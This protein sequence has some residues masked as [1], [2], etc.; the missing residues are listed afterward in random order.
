MLERLEHFIRQQ[1]AFE[2][3]RVAN[4]VRM[5]GGASKETWAFDLCQTRERD[6]QALPMVLRIE[7]SSPLPASLD[8]KKEFLL[9][10]AMFDAGIPVPKPY[11]SGREA[12]GS[13]FYILARIEGETL[14]RRL[15]REERYEK[16][17]RII[18]GQLAEILARIHRIALEDTRFDFLPRRSP[19]DAP[20]LNELLFY[21]RLLDQFS[22]DPHPVIEL[23]MRWLKGHRPPVRDQVLL[24]GDYRLGNI[25]FNEQG[26]Q[27][28]LDWELAHIGD[29]HEDMGYISVQAWRFGQD[30]KPIGG[31]GLRE[32]FY[33]AYEQAGRISLDRESLLYWEIFG[34]LK[35]AIITIL[36][37]NPFLQGASQSIELASLGRK[38]A[39][40][41]LQMLT[42][43]EDR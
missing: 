3:A 28:I 39:E 22:P 32:D 23:V 31:I 21:E 24:H 40:V 15:Q 30:S 38:T 14:V 29:P 12:L 1:P 4:L 33:R 42:L 5:P 27:S 16:A 6:E 35:W 41:E 11:W 36:Q 20:A 13:P 7:R 9:L 19:T 26:V 17:R 34:N 2:K 10:G 25:I 8:L 18:P 37:T 43:I